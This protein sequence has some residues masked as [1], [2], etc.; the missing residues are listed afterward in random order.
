MLRYSTVLGDLLPNEREHVLVDDLE[1]LLRFKQ[2]KARPTQIFVITAPVLSA[3]ILAFWEYPPLEF[4]E[5]ETSRFALLKRVQLIEPLDEQQI[6]D[7]LHDGERVR[8]AA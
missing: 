1:H 5:L 7:L 8:Q 2:L 3:A 4:F 6:G